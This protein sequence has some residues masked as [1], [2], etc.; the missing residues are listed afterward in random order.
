[1]NGALKGAVKG[2]QIVKTSQLLKYA[3]RADFSK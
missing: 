3:L 1:M 2:L